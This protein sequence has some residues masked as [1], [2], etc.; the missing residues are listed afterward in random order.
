MEEG[1]RRV[2]VTMVRCEK[3]FLAVACFEAGG[4]GQHLE[5][6]KSKRTDFSLG[7]LGKIADL[8]LTLVLSQ[9]DPF[10]TSDLQN[11]KILNLC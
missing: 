9:C 7:P 6:G 4:K 1:G 8:L 11:C 3:D 2:S 5:T 10:W